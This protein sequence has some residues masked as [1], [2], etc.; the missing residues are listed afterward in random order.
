[1]TQLT[2]REYEVLR[3]VARGETNLEIAEALHLSPNTV[4]SYLQT[5]LQKL[6]ARNRVEAIARARSASIL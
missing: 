6:G 3:H 4:K 2:P 1:M 5:T